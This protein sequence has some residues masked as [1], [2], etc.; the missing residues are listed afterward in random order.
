M[1]LKAAKIRQAVAQDGTMYKV[2]THA[3]GNETMVLDP[4]RVRGKAAVKRA[5][6]LRRRAS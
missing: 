5:K 2:I 1:F 4:P 6:R 3:N